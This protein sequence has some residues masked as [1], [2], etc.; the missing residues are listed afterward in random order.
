MCPRGPRDAATREAEHLHRSWLL[1]WVILHC[2]TLSARNESLIDNDSV[3]DGKR[4]IA[5]FTNFSRCERYVEQ[6]VFE[7]N[8]DFTVGI[9]RSVETSH[10]P[11]VT[12]K[13]VTRSTYVCTELSRDCANDDGRC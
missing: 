8:A 6:F 12:R 3:D 5:S 10:I 1:Y 7:A 2:A 4:M 11:Y 9:F 13:Y